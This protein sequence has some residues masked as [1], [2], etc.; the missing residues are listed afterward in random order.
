MQIIVQFSD[1]IQSSCDQWKLPGTVAKDKQ[2]Y[3]YSDVVGIQVSLICVGTVNIKKK[4]HS[5][6][7]QLK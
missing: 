2:N 7:I 1:A 5:N 4:L 6:C 3:F